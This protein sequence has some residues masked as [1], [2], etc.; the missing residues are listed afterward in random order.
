MAHPVFANLPTTVF[1]EMSGLARELGAINLGQGFPDGPGPLAI[2][3]KAA[4]EVLNGYNQYPP[5]AGLP[6]LREAVA[7]HY[8]RSQGLDLDWKTE[9][10]ITSGATEALAASFLALVR[11]GDEVVVFQPVYDAYLPLIRRA[12]GVPKLVRLEPPHWR[13]DRAMLEAAFTEKT[14]FVVLNNPIN[15]AGVVLPREDLELL[16]E[17]VIAHDAVAIC[18][19][20]W[21]QV[22]FDGARHIPLMSLPNM[23]ER[24]VKIGSAGKMFG[25]TGWKVGFLCAAPDLTHALARAHQFL[26][27]TT[28][29]NLQ[30]AVAFGL[31][32]PGDWFTAMPAGLQRSRDR[33]A[34]GLTA[35]GF[36]VLPSQGTYFLNVDLA[37]SGVSEPDRAFALRAVKE[38]GVAAIPVSALY[39][40]DPVTRILRLCFSKGDATLDSGVERLARARELS[41]KA[42][43]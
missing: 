1:E 10:T 35:E 40:Q 15:P 28:P 24:T 4:D 39:E 43:G 34:A 2:R 26:T 17:F 25:L 18:D 13:F 41:R 33:L 30:A 11:P 5:M 27:F 20:V 37:A 8:R 32:D 14:R 12:G 3:Q 31:D 42:T 22:V 36:K 16:A 19:E 7:G 23:A 9:V 21:E 38:A 29:P 6:G